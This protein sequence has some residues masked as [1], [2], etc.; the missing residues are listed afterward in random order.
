MFRLNIDYIHAAVHFLFSH[1]YGSRGD[2]LI[3]AGMYRTVTR[4]YSHLPSS[5]L[6]RKLDLVRKWLDD[7]H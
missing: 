2:L 1:D 7:S 3:L 5:T 4:L 6:K